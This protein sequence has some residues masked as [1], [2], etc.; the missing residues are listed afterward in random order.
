MTDS[1]TDGRTEGQTDGQTTELKQHVSPF[2]GGKTQFVVVEPGYLTRDFATRDV[3]Y[4]RYHES[5]YL[6]K[7]TNILYL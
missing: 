3:S 4:F 5:K 2:Y 6:L 1:W 7:R